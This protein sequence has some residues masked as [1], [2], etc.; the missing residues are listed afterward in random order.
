MFWC[1]FLVKV[2]RSWAAKRHSAKKNLAVSCI[3][4]K[5][6]F[7]SYSFPGL[8]L[9]INCLATKLQTNKRTNE[10]TNGFSPANA[11]FGHVLIHGPKQLIIQLALKFGVTWCGVY[12]HKIICICQSKSRLAM[13]SMMSWIKQ[14]ISQSSFVLFNGRKSDCRTGKVQ[15]ISLGHNLSSC[16]ACYVQ[17]WA[18]VYVSQA[19]RYAYEV[20]FQHS[21]QQFTLYWR[22]NVAW[23]P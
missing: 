6:S 14:L 19:M 21:L 9:L 18:V 10:R 8:H 4:I 20:W 13:K 15:V 11:T 22:S 7:E 12:C 16:H 2:A 3:E 17:Y 5:W 23:H 1:S